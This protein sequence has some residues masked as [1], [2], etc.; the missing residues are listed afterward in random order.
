MTVHWPSFWLGMFSPSLL[1]MAVMIVA[2]LASDV[3]NWLAPPERP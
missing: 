3:L 2:A 1:T